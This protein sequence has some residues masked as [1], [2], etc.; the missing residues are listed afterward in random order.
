MPHE[1][2]QHGAARTLVHGHE[3][4][5]L[6]S[7][8]PHL[9]KAVEE[10]PPSI[11]AVARYHFGWF[12]EHGRPADGSPGK[13]LRPALTLLSAQA[14]GD[15]VES[16][17]DAAV[18]IELVHNFSLVHDDVMDGDPTRRHR[19]SA[20]SVFGVPTAVLAGD[21]LLVAAVQTIAADPRAVEV[22]CRAMQELVEGQGRDLS[23]SSRDDV[24]VEECLAMADG[25][26]SALLACACEL[27]ALSGGGTTEQ[28]AAL[29]RFGRHLGIAFQLVDDLLG[30]WGDPAVTGKP[31]LSDLRSRRKSLPVA[32]ALA[33]CPELAELYRGPLDERQLAEIADLVDRAGGRA[34]ARAEADRHVAL[35]LDHLAAAQPV[36][37][38]GR[39]AG[40][41]G[42]AGHR[43]QPLGANTL[44]HI[45]HGVFL[46]G[47]HEPPG[48]VVNPLTPLALEEAVRWTRQLGIVATDAHEKQL[49]SFDLGTITGAG[50]PDADL[51]QLVLAHQGMFWFVL[52]DDQ[53]DNADLTD[54]PDRIR[55]IRDEAREVFAH[56]STSD[57]PFM[58]GLASMWTELERGC[59]PIAR[60][61]LADRFLEYFDAIERQAQYS[62]EKDAPD[63]LEFITMRRATVGMPAWAEFL[64]SALGLHLPDQLREHYVMREIVE[65]STDIQGIGQD[66]HSFEKEELEGYRCNIVPVLMDTFGYTTE[67]AVDRAMRMHRDRQ[68]TL[69]RAEQQ[70]PAV[71][72]R[73]DLRDRTDDAMRFV[74]AVK[75][76][77][78]ALHYWFGSTANQRYD[79]DHPR[80]AGS[81][82]VRI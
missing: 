40:R 69:M 50:M 72:D 8:L 79:L 61:R 60:Q 33:T 29:R 10:L 13:L 27:G 81:F 38:R 39:A 66:V 67:Q 9:R 31:V 78:F 75:G 57:N 34:W 1:L 18:A 2:T 47:F 58:A 42:D 5:V 7:V 73:L 56:R 71:L 4:A 23:F 77:A 28:A 68:L 12:D 82:D 74:A 24:S 70:L 25:K 63:L 32:A 19:A 48:D 54:A 45:D 43:T 17:V 62:A 15:R 3:R 35:A 30:I 55:G 65:C 59:G 14:V 22:L 26:T 20:W 41:S 16:A 52:L 37:R 49:R 36:A 64:D 21:S 6:D 46:P 80:V 53:M 11:R 51:G 76:I 44:P